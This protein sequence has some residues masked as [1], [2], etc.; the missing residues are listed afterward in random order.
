MHR[1][2]TNLALYNSLLN[3]KET[4]EQKGFRVLELGSRLIYVCKY[5]DKEHTF[6]QSLFFNGVIKTSCTSDIVPIHMGLPYGSVGYIQRD[7]SLHG[8]PIGYWIEIYEFI[9]LAIQ[10]PLCTSDFQDRDDFQSH[11][12]WQEGTGKQLEIEERMVVYYDKQ[13]DECVWDTW[14]NYTTVRLW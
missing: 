2:K 1:S 3:N 13:R 7:H 12:I 14:Y 8:L 11:L 5:D 6:R 9:A 10:C 4:Y